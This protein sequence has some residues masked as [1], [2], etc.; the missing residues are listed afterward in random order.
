MMGEE[1]MQFEGKTVDHAI[2]LACQHFGCSKEELEITII[3]K[4]STGLFGL[5]GKKAKIEVTFKGAANG[6][7]EGPAGQAETAPA[8]DEAPDELTEEQGE[9][10]RE[11]EEEAA[12]RRYGPPAE[13]EQDGGEDVSQ[14]AEE[15]IPEEF[16]VQARE[17]LEGLFQRAGFEATIEMDPEDPQFPIRISGPDASL[18]IGREGQTLDALEYVVNRAVHKMNDNSGPQIHLDAGGYRIK[19]M[20]NL[21]HTALRQAKRARST[22]RQMALPPMSARDRRIIHLTLKEFHGV[23]TRSVGEGAK[24]KVIIV[25]KR[26]RG[27]GGGRPRHHG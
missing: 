20:E 13:E 5:G 27:R 9:Q 8:S 3:T 2:E 6:G 19:R 4:G 21:R 12:A 18:I 15:P 22:G 16:L 14:G 23:T 1:K 7:D 25:P 11:D 26:R 24:K 17:Y 10:G